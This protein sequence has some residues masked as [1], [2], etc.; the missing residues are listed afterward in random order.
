MSSST[1]P[2]SV[3]V[4]APM[5]VSF[6]GGGTDF[7]QYFNEHGGAV[8]AATVNLHALVTLYRRSDDLV[9]L[10]SLDL[11]QVQAYGLDEDPTYNGVLDL[12]K[13]AIRRIGVDRGIEVDVRSDAPAGSGLG[14]SSALVTA[15]VAA[16]AAFRGRTLSRHELAELAYVIEREDLAI[17][18]GMQ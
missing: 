4:A 11:G 13:A 16:V 6:A 2:N 10:R 5:R 8:L 3:H 17:P 18:G 9:R 12:L 15:C 1:D 7:P 14:G